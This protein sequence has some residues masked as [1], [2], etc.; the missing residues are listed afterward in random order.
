MRVVRCSR[1]VLRPDGCWF[2]PSI[3]SGVFL[4]LGRVLVLPDR[5]AVEKELPGVARFT[6]QKAR[7]ASWPGPAGTSL[8]HH[9]CLYAQLARERGYDTL[10]VLNDKRSEN[11]GDAT[12]IISTREGCMNQRVPLPNGCVPRS[13]RLGAGWRG[14]EGACSCAE[15]I[16]NGLGHIL[17]CAGA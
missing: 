1:G 14:K 4:T 13:V 6:G 7:A 5:V 9:D 15:A 10:V 16:A 8:H 2:T 11:T 17:N 3:G 12:E